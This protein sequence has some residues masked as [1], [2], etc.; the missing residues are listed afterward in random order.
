MEFNNPLE[1]EQIC[2]KLLAL[3]LLC[4]LNNIIRFLVIITI[5]VIELVLFCCYY[6][7]LF[8]S[9]EDISILHLLS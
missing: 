2:S 4:V 6:D 5:I 8:F 3:I 1:A 7:H 9:P